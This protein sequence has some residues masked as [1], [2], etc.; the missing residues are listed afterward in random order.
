MVLTT[1]E[2]IE[3]S[4]WHSYWHVRSWR[5]R[6]QLWC[7]RTRCYRQRVPGRPVTRACTRATADRRPVHNILPCHPRPPEDQ[8][9][10]STTTASPP[11]LH[12]RRRR[13]PRPQP[14][15]PQDRH[16]GETSMRRRS[17]SWER[18]SRIRSRRP[19]GSSASCRC[20]WWWYLWIS[21]ARCRRRAWR[22]RSRRSDDLGGQCR[23]TVW[24]QWFVSERVQ[25]WALPAPS[26]PTVPTRCDAT[27][28]AHIQNQLPYFCNKNNNKTI[29]TEML[30]SRPSLGFKAVQYHF[31]RSWS[32]SWALNDGLG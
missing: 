11:P 20:R 5:W 24:V 32:W 29:I 9:T 31:C 1:T 2:Y 21:R 22:A 14:G 13:H 8:S 3:L 15:R 7:A 16:V 19:P 6:R 18:S 25:W 17:G 28:A 10:G 23:A 4:P 12:G 26:S 30:A 27:V